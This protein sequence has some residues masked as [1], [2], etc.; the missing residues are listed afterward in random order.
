MSSLP[1]AD[2]R[3]TRTQR[4]RTK[5][6]RAGSAMIVDRSSRYGNPWRVNNSV[7]IAPDGTAREL[8]TPAAARE[9]ASTCY[10]AWLHGEGPDTYAVARKMLD[11]R[12][13]ITG[14]SRLRDRDLA[15]TCPLPS[16]GEPDY[17]HATVLLELATQTERISK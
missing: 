17:C 16:A 4:K 5:I 6:W 7:V 15:C 2:T 12:R 11:R 14:L 9:Q 8:G 3:P 1:Q 10:R 13:V